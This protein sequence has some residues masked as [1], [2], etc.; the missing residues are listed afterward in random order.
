[1]GNSNITDE[2]ICNSY[3]K[4][5]FC[6]KQS[7]VTFYMIAAVWIKPS[8]CENVLFQ[9]LLFVRLCISNTIVVLVVYA[10]SC[11]SYNQLGCEAR[12]QKKVILVDDYIHSVLHFLEV[13][14]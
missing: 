10:C 8:I 2:T 3:L 13:F 5:C 6:P 4:H 7:F 11:Q 1:M 12:Q 14:D 9:S